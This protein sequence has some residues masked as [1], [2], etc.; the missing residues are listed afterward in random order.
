[1][2]KSSSPY[3]S[4]TPVHACSTSAEPFGKTIGKKGTTAAGMSY[5]SA[6]WL[7]GNSN[8][9]SAPPETPASPTRAPNIA[10]P[11]DLSPT[12]HWL[13][14]S[15]RGGGRKKKIKFSLLAAQWRQ[16][17]PLPTPD[18]AKL[19]FHH[20]IAHMA[21]PRR[22]TEINA[23]RSLSQ[24]FINSFKGQGLIFHLL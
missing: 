15:K 24:E 4:Q 3:W 21:S 20:L 19:S 11:S 22:H 8:H 7:A 2:G 10:P 18:S 16:H 13:P 12:A 17:L 23:H 9:P 14:Q 5:S 1:M 6:Q